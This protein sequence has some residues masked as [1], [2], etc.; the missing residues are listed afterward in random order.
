M[1]EPA[2]DTGLEP[3]PAV[4]VF[5]RRYLSMSETFISDHLLHLKTWRPLAA[6]ETLKVNGLRP[7][8]IEARSIYKTKGAT[9]QL[10]LALLGRNRHLDGLVSAG[11]VKLLHAHFLPDGALL[12]R[13]ASRSG[14]PLVVTAHGYDA[15]MRTSVQL[16]RN[17]GRAYHVLRPTLIKAVSAVI[18]VSDFIRGELER[19]GFPPEKL[20]TLRL[21]VDPDEFT[22]G[23]PAA[24]RAGVLFVGRMVEKKGLPF[25]LR[26]W[27][28]L[29][30]SLRQTPL[31]IIGDG[32]LRDRYEALARH[33][34]V[35][36]RFL[37]ARPRQEVLALMRSS[38]VFTLPS[39]RARSGDSEGLPVV[40]MEAQALGTP[41]V[42][43]DEGPGR[44]AILDGETGL[45]ARRGDPGALAQAIAAVLTDDGLATRLG[46]GGP[47]FI[48]RRYNL[49][50][51][52]AQLERLYDRVAGVKLEAAPRQ[53]SR[54]E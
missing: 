29:P 2:P 53:A 20:V 43:F 42:I 3:R 36:A 34:G 8:G 21:G 23:P 46:A 50:T 38:R 19:K 28:L 12:A 51:N 25:L 11:G 32:D 52:V 4:M 44:E 40:L 49:R 22:P 6:Y 45:L 17:E 9:D 18:C 47:P 26:A 27:T 1:L 16:R 31:N 24:Q 13:F 33:L 37:G 30:K 54:T 39:A 7:P 15:T 35:P 14:L 5:R 48:R 10:A 41:V